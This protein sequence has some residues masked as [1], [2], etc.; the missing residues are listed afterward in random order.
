MPCRLTKIAAA[1]KVYGDRPLDAAMEAQIQREMKAEIDGEQARLLHGRY[2]AVIPRLRGCYVAVTWLSRGCHV[3][4]TRLLRD[5][6][7]SEELSLPFHC[8]TLRD[9]TLRHIPY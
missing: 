7:T 9:V 4:V 5:E 6:R 8:V 1:A 3:A 2:M